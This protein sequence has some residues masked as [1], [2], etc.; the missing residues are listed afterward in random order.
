LRHIHFSK[1]WREEAVRLPHAAAIYF[2]PGGAFPRP[3]PD[4]SPVL[5]GRLGTGFPAGGLPPVPAFMPLDFPPPDFAI[6]GSL[7]SWLGK[8]AN[9]KTKLSNVRRFFHTPQ[10]NYL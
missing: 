2:F 4:F 3:P 8:S 5:L 1:S 10:S 6:F 7:F 9:L